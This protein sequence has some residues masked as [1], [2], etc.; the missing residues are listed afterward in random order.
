MAHYNATHD[1]EL[2][3]IYDLHDALTKVPL[4]LQVTQVTSAVIHI[5]GSQLLYSP[6]ITRLTCDLGFHLSNV[7]SATL[8]FRALTVDEMQVILGLAMR[9]LER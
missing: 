7:L 9:R 8:N 5:L 1:S 3:F 2:D 6:T 4:A